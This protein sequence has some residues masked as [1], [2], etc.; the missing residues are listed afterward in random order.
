[1][2]RLE[3]QP[4]LDQLDSILEK[5]DNGD[6]TVYIIEH[7]GK[8]FVC[9]PYD[10]PYTETVMKNEEDDLFINLPKRVCSKLG[11]KEGDEVTFEMSEDN[12]QI[13]IT[14]K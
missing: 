14:K 3:L 7:E 13:K 8:D 5:Y 12:S 10:G 6:N 11:V 9:T 4:F 2:T 1:M